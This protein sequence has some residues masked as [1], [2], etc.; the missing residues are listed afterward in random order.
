MYLQFTPKST[1]ETLPC[2]E[3][4]PNTELL[5]PTWGGAD[6]IG[7]ATLSFI[8]SITAKDCCQIYITLIVPPYKKGAPVLGTHCPAETLYI[9]G[10]ERGRGTMGKGYSRSTI[11]VWYPYPTRHTFFSS[12]RTAVGWWCGV[13]G[14]SGLVSI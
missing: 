3:Q 14:L 13:S 10:K 7:L 5:L 11:C 1:S 9:Y 4:S 6:L 2:Y 12:S 8:E